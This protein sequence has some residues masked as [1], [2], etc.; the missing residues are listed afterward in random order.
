MPSAQAPSHARVIALP[1]WR[2]YRAT[3]RSVGGKYDVRAPR[4]GR[5]IRFQYR[6]GG[7]GGPFYTGE[8]RVVGDD[9]D[10]D[11]DGDGVACDA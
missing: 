3:V 4:G 6:A 7:S 5:V 9:L 2:S 11:R 8:V 1:G 10:L